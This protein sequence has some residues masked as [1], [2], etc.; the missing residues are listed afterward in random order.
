LHFNSAHAR[1]EKH[2]RQGDS[3]GFQ[4]IFFT[5]ALFIARY[6]KKFNTSLL[7]VDVGSGDGTLVRFLK[8]YHPER[9]FIGIEIDPE[10]VNKSNT[11]FLARSDVQFFQCDAVA[12]PDFGPAVYILFN[13]FGEKSMADFLQRCVDFHKLS[14]NDLFI[15]Y[16]ND[17]FR[18]VYLDFP[19]TP[20][21][22]SR[23]RATSI[24]KLSSL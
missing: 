17:Q 6:I 15:I 10:L 13:P 18:N 4:T 1:A 20:V 3:T 9:A 22:S 21:Y 12:I 5:D 7:I 14:T 23:I 2:G 19:F 11:F 16:V 24:Y 8:W